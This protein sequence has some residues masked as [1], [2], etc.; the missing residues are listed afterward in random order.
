MASKQS[1]AV[2]RPYRRDAPAHRCGNNLLMTEQPEHDHATL[3]ARP[4]RPAT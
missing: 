3:A 2:A 1:E 4:N